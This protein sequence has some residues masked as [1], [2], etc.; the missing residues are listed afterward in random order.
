MKF[1]PASEN[2]TTIFSPFNSV[3]PLHL[4]MP[5]SYRL[6][7]YVPWSILCFLKMTTC[8][9]DIIFHL[10]N[11]PRYNLFSRQKFMITTSSQ[12]LLQ[13]INSFIH[14]TKLI[15]YLLYVRHY[16]RALG[17]S[18]NTEE[19]ETHILLGMRNNKQ[20]NEIPNFR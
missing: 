13:E 7:C 3:F 5:Y 16:F 10:P 4:S 9:P 8:Y 2:I 19:S 11:S 15:E 18:K 1:K 6:G 12:L 14:L 20:V 17:Y